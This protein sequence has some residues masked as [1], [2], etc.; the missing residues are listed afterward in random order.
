MKVF[1][2]GATGFV[3]NEVVRQLHDAGHAIRIL[4]R[5]KPLFRVEGPYGSMEAEVRVGDILNAES[6]KKALKDI[7]A[8]I[9]LVG[10]IS[11]V[12]V[13]TFENVHVRG[14]G[15]IVTAAH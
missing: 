15:N 13:S 5:K 14:T 1:V 9:H 4:V 2:T 8:V 6:L 11:E 10:I 12:G 3:G 7:D